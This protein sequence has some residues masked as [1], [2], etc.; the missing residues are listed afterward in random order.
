MR[1][2]A[3]NLLSMRGEAPIDSNERVAKGELKNGHSLS[4]SNNPSVG[5]VG[6]IYQGL[7]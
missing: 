4:H 5:I 6:L 2:N 1:S 3:A 7:G